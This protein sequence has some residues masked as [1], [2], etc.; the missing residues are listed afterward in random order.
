MNRG[1]LA[2]GGRVR[3]VWEAG[4]TPPLTSTSD[5]EAAAE[6]RT[7]L[8][9]RLEY[10]ERVDQPLVLIAQVARSGG[11]LLLRLFDGHRH[12]HVVPYE[13]QRIFRGMASDL[14]DHERAWRHLAGD[15]QY[16]RSR[17]FLLRPSLQRAIFE[18]CLGELP[19]PGPREVMNCFFTSY[20]NGWLDNANL[21]STPKRWV[22]GFEPGETTALDAYM[23]LYPDGRVI[24]LVRDPWS[25]Y[26]SRRKRKRKWV[27]LELALDAWRAH[28]TAALQLRAGDPERVL[29]VPFS[30]LLDRTEATMKAL[31]RW[32]DIPFE[33]TLVVPSF[34]GMAIGARSSFSD[35]RA[36]ISVAPL[37]RGAGLSPEETS[38]IEQR[39]RDLY[40][41][42]VASAVALEP[43]PARRLG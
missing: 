39:A 22:V 38:F 1:K 43:E 42:A 29:L 27:N 20:F 9:H 36:E 19:D 5:R 21:R 16:N 30:E 34:N 10:L 17:P 15:K 6:Y 8:E 31:A 4:S 41:Q 2:R 33:P 37:E 25:W 28:V 13:L 12:C 32:L 18:A 3:R 40:E 23:R 35:V 24:S 26:A 7:V 14:S 11:T